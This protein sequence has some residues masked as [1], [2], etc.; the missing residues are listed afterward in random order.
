[1]S[2]NNQSSRIHND[3]WERA[4]PIKQGRYRFGDKSLVEEYNALLDSKPGAFSA[5]GSLANAMADMID[6]D[7]PI[8]PEIRTTPE[9]RNRLGELASLIDNHCIKRL[10]Q[11]ELI[12]IGFSIPRHPDDP[13]RIIPPEIL[14]RGR[15]KFDSNKVIG[16]GLQ[17]H[18]VRIFPAEALNTASS[19]PNRPGRPSKR[20]LIKKVYAECRNEGL[21]DYTKPQKA[22]IDVIKSR[23]Q[24]R[25]FD[26]YG[27]GKGF[28]SE[29][30][31]DCIAD[32]FGQR[33]KDQKL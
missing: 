17:F 23:I 25:Y 22:A 32:D 14:A 19:E 31:R 18:A 15:L 8:E 28:G 29:V 12:A 7:P 26:E 27:L 21:I 6:G 3:L 4:I 20:D 1:M 33:A 2:Q 10:Q 9:E 11:R 5:L 24:T 16:D 30:I 13:P